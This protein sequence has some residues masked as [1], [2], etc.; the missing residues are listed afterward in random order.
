MKN[1]VLPDY[2]NCLMNITTTILKHYGVKTKYKSLPVL[3][4]ELNKGYRNV[5]YILI[6]AMGDSILK[7]HEDVTEYL[8]SNQ[9]KTLTTVFPSTTTSATTSVLT[10]KP[11]IETGWIGW[12]QYIKEEDKS[13]IFFYNQDFYDESIKFDYN[14]SDKYAPV[15]RI[16]E[17]IKESNPEIKTNEIF[18]EFR[19]PEHKEFINM[20][21]TIIKECNNDNKNFIYAYWDKL[22]TFIHRNGTESNKVHS[23]IKQ[24]NEDLK[25]LREKLDDD[26][27]II[28]T[29][30]HGQIDIEEI[31]LFKYKELTETF[32]HNPSIEAR[33][34]AF[35][36]K[37]D[38]KSKFE[39][40]FNTHFRDK[41]ILFDS[42]DFIK[43][44]MLG[45]GKEH[46]KLR[47]FL[48]DYFSVAIDKY[49]FK[50][51]NSKREF[52]SQH[53]GLTKEEML[54]PLIIL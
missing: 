7:K 30:D 11:P 46:Y 5:V 25:Y 36:I 33:A 19:V 54:I 28:V 39:E 4:K 27:I 6:D 45:I 50:L 12:L 44:N 9:T 17:L 8:R 22:D 41:F 32:V 29:A 21:D 51:S 1:I 15:K 3:E 13:I 38:M 24:L 10:G 18:P 42:A 40:E 48:G 2:E 53:A 20:C 47:E 23:H 49:T 14:V 43:T 52:K 31:E 37:E 26:T 34:T 35:F 16:Y